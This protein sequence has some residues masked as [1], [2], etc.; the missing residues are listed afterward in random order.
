MIN[1]TESNKKLWDGWSKI[2]FKSD[3]YN[4]EDFKSGKSSLKKVELSELGDVTAKTM[5]HLQCHFGMDTLSWAKEGAEVTGVDLSSESI[6][7]AEQLSN[8]LSIPANFICSDIYDLP[9]VLDKK[10]DIVFTSYGVLVWLSNL[11]KWADIVAHYLKPGGTFY[12]VEFHPFTNMFGESWEGINDSYFYGEQPICL[13]QSNSYA[14]SDTEFNHVSYEWPH[15]MSEVINALRKAGLI[16]E[17]FHEFPFSVY[18]C[19][20]SLEENNK[21]EFVIK[22]HGNTIPLMYS[23]KATYMPDLAEK[24]KE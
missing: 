14:D 13:P 3:F 19:F 8:E 1:F 17:F 24:T 20:P 21:D 15:T 10:F 22:G 6:E 11:N 4:V 9:K 23:I 16:I 7:L 2:N 5:L 18:N 12:I